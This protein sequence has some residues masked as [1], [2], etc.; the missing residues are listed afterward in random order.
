MKLY[1]ILSQKGA[2]VYS[3]GPRA[4]L[5]EMAEKLIEHNCGSLL[6]MD[7]GRMVGIITERDVLRSFVKTRKPLT[8]L[9]VADFMTA[10]VVTGTPEDDVEDAMGLMT[11]RRIR[12]LPILDDNRLAGL[13]SIGDVVKAQHDTLSLENHFMKSYIQG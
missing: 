1:E 6:V 9:L 8:E 3:I 4:T 5:A 2:I 11:R 7:Q 13:I 12:H 10:D